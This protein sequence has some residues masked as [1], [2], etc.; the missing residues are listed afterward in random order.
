MLRKIL[1]VSPQYFERLGRKDDPADIG[2]RLQLH[3]LLKKN[4]VQPYD[5]WNKMRG[6]QKH[7]I[8]KHKKPGVP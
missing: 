8:G 1:L 2:A 3:N 6:L 4:N 5:K 7:L